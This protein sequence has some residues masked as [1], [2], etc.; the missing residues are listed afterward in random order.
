MRKG[1]ATKRQKELLLAI[2]NSIKNEGYPP[3]FEELKEKMGIKSNQA[4]ID[5]LTALEKRGLI[6]KED[7]AARGIIIKPLGY[8][9]IK[10]EPLV[11]IAGASAAGPAI[12]AIEQ[13][14]WLAMPSG[15]QKY[16]DVYIVK[17]NGN[18]MVEADIYDGDN[19]LI[20]KANEYKSGDIV[21]AR[22]GDDVT[23]KTFIAK[24]GRTFLKPE[25]PACRDIAITHDT[26]FLGKMI[27][28]LG[29]K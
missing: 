5:H 1:E 28:N 3:T 27:T 2:Y 20:K 13:N 17:V 19:V 7:G 10:K 4:I 16:E 8:E 15:F 18:S 6:K 21:L 22:I 25:N 12:A 24:D 11:R 26:Y 9:T 29:R 14:E 23:L